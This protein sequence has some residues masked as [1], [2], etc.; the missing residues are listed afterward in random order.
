MPQLERGT[1]WYPQ[2]FLY[3]VFVYFRRAIS[4]FYQHRA[5]KMKINNSVS[6]WF[7]KWCY[8][9]KETRESRYTT[10]IL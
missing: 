5:T 10:W 4:F 2:V 1:T 7:W 9:W 3:L 8:D 6:G